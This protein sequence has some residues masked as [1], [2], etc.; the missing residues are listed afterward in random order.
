[1][2]YTEDLFNRIK[3][4][5]KDI[6][7]ATYEYFWEKIGRG[8]VTKQE[9]T[10]IHNHVIMAQLCPLL[11]IEYIREVRKPPIPY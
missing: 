6:H 8:E 1:M 10:E 3:D 2:K 7:E 9:A 11:G 5:F 4:K